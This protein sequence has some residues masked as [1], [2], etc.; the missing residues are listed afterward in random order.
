MGGEHRAIARI[1]PWLAI[2]VP[3]V[4]VTLAA[5]GVLTVRTAFVV[6][7]ALEI[8]L[9]GVLVIEV[10]TFRA[11]Y[12]H[13]RQ[14]G[15]R[16]AESTAKGIDAVLPAPVAYLMRSEVGL[17]VALW[18]AVRRQHCVAP[19][20]IE[21]SYVSRIG[22]MLWIVI[23]LGF[24]EI[25]VVHM[26]LPWPIVRWVV[27]AVSIYGQLWLL[28]MV[29]S[30]RQHPHLLRP[31]GQLLLRFAHFRTTVVPLDRLT[32]VRSRTTTE[33]PRNLEIKDGRLSVSVMGETSVQL[34]FTP[35]VTVSLK[36]AD[37]ECITVDF[38]ADSP[39]ETVDHLRSR[40]SI[41]K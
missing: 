19:G 14:Q 32:A 38:F 23:G 7:L 21:I 17:A 13:A 30:L 15:A 36:G 11:T 39:R 35:A 6:A 1:A 40:L 9:A 20:D 3:L 29:F 31:D 2:L 28:A 24:V 5:T 27:L 33:H 18:R 41:G 12:R 34:E 10:A 37:H 22:M 8:L 4:N 16:R 25:A 26:L